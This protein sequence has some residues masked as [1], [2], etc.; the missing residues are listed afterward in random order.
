MIA[1][2]GAL[3]IENYTDKAVLYTIQNYLLKEILIMKI[4]E[5]IEKAKK[6]NNINGLK[7]IITVK[8]YLPFV[9]KQELIESV[10]ESCKVVTNGYIQF[11]EMKK[12]IVFTTSVIQAYT[13]LEFST[14]YDELI[15]EY[16]MLCEY[17]LLNE[18]VELFSAEYNATLSMLSMKADFILKSNSIECQITQFLYGLNNKL[19]TA[20]ESLSG[21]VNMFKESITEEDIS[22]LTDLLKTLG[23]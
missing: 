17:G 8:N 18:I 23:N 11:D 15:E 9:E 14:D 22:K 12:Y 5:F 1:G 20:L 2:I 21:Q 19:D 13:N 4:K 6:T 7:N 3:K 16:D 10:T